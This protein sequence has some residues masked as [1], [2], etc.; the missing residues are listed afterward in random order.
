M[1]LDFLFIF[2]IVLILFFLFKIKKDYD[3][4]LIYIIII[5]LVFLFFNY[6][7]Y[8]EDI[9]KYT[10]N[11][12]LIIVFSIIIFL[13]RKSFYSEDNYT[14]LLFNTSIIII[15]SGLLTS[16]LISYIGYLNTYN[17]IEN[18]T[19]KNIDLIFNLMKIEF[20]H[21]NEIKI[22]DYWNKLKPF[23][24][25]NDIYFFDNNNNLIFSTDLNNLY[26]DNKEYFFYEKTYNSHKIIISL[27]RKL[28]KNKSL[29][30]IL[31]LILSILFISIIILPISILLLKNVY[32]IQERKINKKNNDLILAQN[33]LENSLKQKEILLKEIHHR[34]KNNLQVVFSL[35]GLQINTINDEKIIYNLSEIQKRIRSMSIIH[36][37]LYQNNNLDKI[38]FKEYIVEL[39]NYI[40]NSYNL[41][42]K[43]KINFNLEEHYLDIDKSIPCGLIIN[44]ILSNSLKHS[45]C[46]IIN[47]L[48]T[49]NENNYILEILDNGNGINNIEN[50]DKSKSLG[51]KLVNKLSR[52][53]SG[54]ID[55]KNSNGLCFS[56][57]FPV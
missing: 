9:S 2:L 26:L 22:L 6:F 23:D 11:I 1:F 30:L 25:D 53:L 41:Y 5:S 45:N 36:E 31:P 51:L 50:I 35:I 7:Y 39:S 13:Y 38:N 12:T 46:N 32:S 24:T 57:I 40:I 33:N 21:K 3:K 17:Y 43:I 27:K 54:K 18:K 20:N 10:T 56:L 15:F 8:Y 28:I 42:S 19:K 55:Y 48:F 37:K 47:I 44:E 52:Q 16:I 4:K 14:K 34:V 49:E 29:N